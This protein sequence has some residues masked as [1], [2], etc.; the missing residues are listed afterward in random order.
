MSIIM[1]LMAKCSMNG[2]INHSNL[3]FISRLEMM[4]IMKKKNTS[5]YCKMWILTTMEDTS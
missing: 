2:K 4:V 3:T 5:N 1:P